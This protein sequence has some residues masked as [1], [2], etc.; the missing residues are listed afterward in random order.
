MFLSSVC[1]SLFILMFLTFKQN[2]QTTK[3]TIW[4]ICLSG[5]GEPGSWLY[6]LLAGTM[7]LLSPSSSAHSSMRPYKTQIFLSFILTWIFSAWTIDAK[8]WN[9]RHPYRERVV[10]FYTVSNIKQAQVNK[11]MFGQLS[12][13]TKSWRRQWKCKCAALQTNM[14][15]VTQVAKGL[16]CSRGS[17]PSVGIKNQL[18]IWNKNPKSPVIKCLDFWKYNYSLTFGVG[19]KMNPCQICKL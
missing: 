11:C 16:L 15:L 14:D 6:G 13:N 4:L 12:Y 2:N 10:S 1:P 19:E 18:L 17:A 3:N 5:I 9:S 7:R 8:N